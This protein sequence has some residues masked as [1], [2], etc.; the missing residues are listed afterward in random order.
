MAERRRAP[1]SAAAARARAIPLPVKIYLRYGSHERTSIFSNTHDKTIDS[2]SATIEHAYAEALVLHH[3]ENASRGARVLITRGRPLD[4]GCVYSS[5]AH[6]ATCVRHRSCGHECV[7]LD[8]RGAQTVHA[9]RDW[10]ERLIALPTAVAESNETLRALCLPASEYRAF[11]KAPGALATAC[12][13]RD[14]VAFS[15]AAVGSAATTTSLPVHAAA[16][17]RFPDV[18][19]S[20]AETA[21]ITALLEQCLH[22]LCPTCA[23]VTAEQTS[24]VCALCAQ[25]YHFTCQKIDNDDDADGGA[26]SSEFEF[27]CIEC[28]SDPNSLFA[29]SG[30]AVTRDRKTT[31][32]RAGKRRGLPEMSISAGLDDQQQAAFAA[33]MEVIRPRLPPLPPPPP[34]PPATKRARL[35]AAKA[36]AEAAALAAATALDESE[37]SDDDDHY[38]HARTG[39]S[40]RSASSNRSSAPS[41]PALLLK[42]ASSEPLLPRPSTHGDNAANESVHAVTTAATAVPPSTSLL[43][44]YSNA[45]TTRPLVHM[46]RVQF[47]LYDQAPA[48][49]KLLYEP[50]PPQP[51]PQP[52]PESPAPAEDESDELEYDVWQH[53]SVSLPLLPTRVDGGDADARVQVIEFNLESLLTR[54]GLAAYVPVLQSQAIGAA[55]LCFLSTDDWDAI[56]P[57]S[58]LGARR[59]LQSVL[60][61]D[62]W[63]VPPP[64]VWQRRLFHQEHQTASATA[65]AVA[66]AA[67]ALSAA[68]E[69]REEAHAR[70]PT[71]EYV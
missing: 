22:E 59:L 28:Q 42:L 38:D 70:A 6:A 36:E 53:D 1:T 66:V 19:V 15:T 18:R 29:S 40:L 8:M 21:R 13:M 2:A 14:P 20:P 48:N 61:R 65:A 64:I 30:V 5:M 45:R 9:Q 16:T 68:E 34:P 52:M 50:A 7:F 25:H 24:F 27:T 60:L 39:R 3:D 17:H 43:R 57:P 47:N 56:F 49:V 35:A 55:D 62:H 67:D 26:N 33:D 11:V 37:C 58:T 44:F 10:H 69:P 46:Q 71:S 4:V 51:Q 31:A 12:T 41:R 32:P 63:R 23:C 54:F